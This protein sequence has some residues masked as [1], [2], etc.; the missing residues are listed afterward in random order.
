VSDFFVTLVTATACGAQSNAI[1]NAKV[2]ISDPL[3]AH[4]QQ[5]LVYTIRSCTTWSLIW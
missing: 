3:E 5:M 1:T 2:E 4:R